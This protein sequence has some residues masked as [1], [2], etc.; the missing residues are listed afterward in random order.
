MKHVLT[1][2]LFLLPGM[3]LAQLK[4]DFSANITSGCNPIVVEFTNQSTGAVSYVWNLG[5]NTVT[6]QQHP[7]VSYTDTGWITVKLVITAA[8]GQKDSIV[9][10]QYIRVNA[11]PKV[12]FTA[13]AT[14]G[15]FPLRAQFFDAS[16]PEA[17]SISTWLWDF[18][19]GTTSALKNPEHIYT[20]AG[21]FNVTLQVTNSEGCKSTF[22][23]PNYIRLSDG[24]KADFS[25]SAPSSCKPP[26]SIQFTNA[27]SGTGSRTFTWHFGDGN[28]STVTNPAYSYNTPGTYTVMLVALNDKGCRDTMK[29]EN[30]I[31]IGTVK[32]DFSVASPACQ[33]NLVQ[34]SNTST[35]APYSAFWEFSDGGTAYGLNATHRFANAGKH[36]VKITSYFG[37]CQDVVT[38]EIDILPTPRPD[39]STSD[40]SGCSVP[41]PITFNN[42]STGNATSY[43]W[44]FDDGGTSTAASPN[45]TYTNTGYFSPSLVAAGANGCR[46]SIEKRYLIN[47]VRP[48]IVFYNAY[49][50]GCAP[51]T[52]RPIPYVSNTADAVVK[53]E[54]YF[55]DGG[56]SSQQSPNY[57]YT[58]A[59]VYNVKLV[60]TTAG[61]C[62]DSVT[63]ISTVRV[64]GKSGRDFSATPLNGCANDPVTFTQTGNGNNADL[65]LFGD[66]ASVSGINA[67]HQYSDTG[68]FTVRLV[69]YNNGCRDTITKENYIFIKPPIARFYTNPV[70]CNTPFERS[71]TDQSIEPLTWNWDFGD[72]TGSSSSSPSHTY[73]KNGV[74]NVTL[75]VTN[76]GCTNRYTLPVS[77][78]VSTPDLSISA[79][80]TCKNT[81]AVF[82]PSGI[83]TVSNAP[84]VSWQFT[85]TRNGDIYYNSS[86]GSTPLNA[87]LPEAGR[88][89]ITMR[90]TNQYGCTYTV[91]KTQAI[92]IY[93]PTARY[94]TS[95]SRPCI[96]ETVNLND[97]SFSDGKHPIT[98]WIWAY[99]ENAA[100]TLASGPFQYKFTTGGAKYPAL[101]V[102]DSRGCSHTGPMVYMFV[103]SPKA[104]FFAS[105]TESCDNKPVRFTNNS[106][107]DLP[108]YSWDFGNGKTSNAYEPVTQYEGD[109]V[110][111]VRLA[112]RDFYGCTDTLIQQNA[113][114]IANPVAA[115]TVSDSL[116]TCPPLLVNFTNTSSNFSSMI[117]DFGDN[118]PLSPLGSPA[119]F[120]NTP[121][122]F[123]AKIYI[124]SIGGC[125]DTAT[126]AIVVRGPRGTM[127]YNGITGCVPVK[128]ALEAITNDEVSF[129]WDYND[130]ITDNT[131]AK[132]T[133]HTYE[134]AGTYF[135]KLILVDADGCK[136][137]IEGTDPVEVKGVKAH[138]GM[139]DTTFCDSGIL[140]LYDSSKGN[141]IVTHHTW[142]LGEGTVKN[143]ANIAHTYTQT[144][145]YPVKLV[146][147]TATGCTDSMETAA[148]VI[149]APSPEIG[150]TGMMEACE[151]AVLQFNGNILRND[152]S[153]LTWK[154][155]LGNGEERNTISSGPVT[156]STASTYP[157][158][159]T[160]STSFGCTHRFSANAIVHPTPPINAG[161]NAVICLGETFTLQP[162]GGARY[163]WTPHPDLPCTDCTSPKVTP[164]D[165]RKY[166]VTGYSNFGCHATDSIEL[167]VKQPFTI[168]YSSA[169]TL[170]NGASTTLFAQG[171][172]LYSWSPTSAISNISSPNPTVNPTVTTTY[173]V[174]GRD[175]NNCF[176]DTGRVTITV[177]PVP[178]VQAG[179]DIT[180]PVGS[181]ANISA[182]FSADVTNIRWTPSTGLNCADCPQP[183]ASPKN[184]TT[185]RV[186]GSNPGAC[187]SS[188]EL[189]VH[190]VCNDGNLFVPNT[191]SPNGDNM[192]DILYPR[193]KGIY[194]IR[195][196]RI[197]DRW[198]QQVFE[199]RNFL[200]NE[201]NKGW[202]GTFKGK[203]LDPNVFVYTLEVVCEN[204][205]VLLFKGNIT[206]V[207]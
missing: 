142:H 187:A 206:L 109:G 14:T 59:G 146:I 108:S 126:K 200:A 176:T 183:F 82:T 173:Q 60:I 51:L 93:G 199:Q 133:E 73:T 47:I 205:Q 207:R 155:N 42:L 99:E 30:A 181:G 159:L 107:A 197:F 131:T 70:N 163:V 37:A 122:S 13:S 9:K 20:R 118:S 165:N 171:A 17:G 68:R 27:S 21:N 100:D 26:T 125:T 167:R 180:I 12:N 55:G 120:Y 88:Y 86:Y 147:Q 74:Y 175:D 192:N 148:P 2:L 182:A 156:Y 1:A 195:S 162:T 105:A 31:T 145:R 114:T 140:Q 170:C 119:H 186:T 132:T 135:P 102:T 32:A 179:T 19:D 160:A 138:F 28:T 177:Y 6:T 5:N 49:A 91:T 45:H 65:W 4:A 35:P 16:T 83:S 66:G 157:V 76:G 136:I 139:S 97:L 23:K 39:F 96:N 124:S 103:P 193:G 22:S 54:W 63:Y 53:Y 25:F 46:D 75:T 150:F 202:N 64:G 10:N 50:E 194:G 149:V 90:V 113:V 72:N 95:K 8:N 166:F 61:G 161:T 57:I 152:T 151:P 78:E 11:S 188:D 172:E 204:N 43:F 71:F 104:S 121:D 143:G 62:K 168:T 191:F 38:K 79:T 128:V 89:D 203:L 77:I 18:G 117:W 29:Q 127:Q 40:S 81:M 33:R 36:T 34:F 52:Y 201:A 111:T 94:S 92:E 154:W 101:T 198:G 130:G 164:V 116:S 174:I 48:Y 123:L 85:N 15:C 98:Q 41:F 56:Y 129:I 185:Y 158:T 189:T 115:F 44:R 69:T 141:D 190:V 178:V 169:D 134:L 24:V 137:P 80:E 184:T 106:S 67:T 3:L 7:K 153:T 87:A 112:V 58:T 84:F 196:F 110:Y 144:G